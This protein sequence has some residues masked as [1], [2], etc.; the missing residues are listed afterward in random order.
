[1]NCDRDH[2]LSELLCRDLGHLRFHS[3]I[4]YFL[5]P[6]LAQILRADAHDG[7]LII[8]LVSH[9]YKVLPHSCSH[10]D[11]LYFHQREV[12]TRPFDLAVGRASVSFAGTSA[13]LMGFGLAYGSFHVRAHI[14]ITTS[15]ARTC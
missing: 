4:F 1:M 5:W 6:I 14:R 13:A 7:D 12:Q 3:I 10:L 11:A 8:V 15:L 2:H 9:R